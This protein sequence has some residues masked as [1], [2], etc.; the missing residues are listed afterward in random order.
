MEISQEVKYSHRVNG[1]CNFMNLGTAE[2]SYREQWKQSPATE[3]VVNCQI[4]EIMTLENVKDGG[5]RTFLGRH[6]KHHIQ[7]EVLCHFFPPPSF[8]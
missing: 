1:S 7:P 8:A 2:K 3:T 6:L 5:L 4:F